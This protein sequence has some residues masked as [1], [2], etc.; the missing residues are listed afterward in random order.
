MKKRYIKLPPEASD[1]DHW[2]ASPIGEGCQ[3]SDILT[4]WANHCDVDD[5]IMLRIVEMTDEEFD[6]LTDI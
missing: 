5:V 4:E 2:T 3:L 6:T 1:G